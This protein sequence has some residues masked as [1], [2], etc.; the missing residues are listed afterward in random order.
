MSLA[1]VPTAFRLNGH[2]VVTTTPLNTFQ[3]ILLGTDGT[4]THLLSAYADEAIEIVKLQQVLDAAEEDDAPLELSGNEMLLR[5]RVLLR[6]KRSKQNLLYAEAVVVLERVAPAFAE[7]LVDTD[8]PIGVLLGEN[9]MET[10][11]EILVIDR[12]AAGSCADHFGIDPSDELIM[13]TYRIV[14][15]GQPVL[16]ITEKFPADSFGDMP[17]PQRSAQLRRHR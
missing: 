10:F 6:G 11:R 4:V 16:L 3:R 14:V 2:P 13:R 7:A 9:R 8:K 15:Q 5:R 12:E 17:A 1:I